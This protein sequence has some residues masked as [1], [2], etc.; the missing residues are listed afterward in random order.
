MRL[1]WNFFFENSLWGKKAL[2][3]RKVQLLYFNGEKTNFNAKFLVSYSKIYE[4]SKETFLTYITLT[5]DVLIAHF[6]HLRT[7]GLKSYLTNV[8]IKKMSVIRYKL[9][10]IFK[11]PPLVLISSYFYCYLLVIFCFTL[12]VGEVGSRS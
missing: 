6:Y 11:N 3:I 9:K 12:F 10:L 5:Y 1:F 2:S 8:L 4:F 7:L